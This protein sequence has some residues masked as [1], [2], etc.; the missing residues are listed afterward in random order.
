M[1]GNVESCQKIHGLHD[2]LL[3]KAC[4]CN[5]KIYVMYHHAALLESETD[6][7]IN[8][9]WRHILHIYRLLQTHF[10]DS[11]SSIPTEGSAIMG[12]K[13]LEHLHYDLLL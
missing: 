8:F 9:Y 10:P 3:H 4:C 1:S 6:R 11:S 13:Y 7:S 5:W 2:V 12:N